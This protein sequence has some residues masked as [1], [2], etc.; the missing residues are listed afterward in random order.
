[1]HF[2]DYSGRL[3]FLGLVTAFFNYALGTYNSLLVLYATGV[4]HQSQAF[5]YQLYAAFNALVFTLPI[6]GGY[7]AG[8]FSYKLAAWVGTLF[9]FFA[10]LI[11]ACFSGEPAYAGFVLYLSL[12]LYAAGYGLALPAL[13]AMPGM[14]F[15]KDDPERAGG[16]TLF[17]ILM[18][19]GFLA[20]PI[21]GGYLSQKV[22]YQSAYIAAALALFFAVAL[23]TFGLKRVKFHE[24]YRPDHLRGAR[25][26]KVVGINSLM[27]VLVCPLA[28]LFLHE[29]RASNYVVAL[30][31]L[32][33][34]VIVLVLAQRQTAQMARKRLHA[35]LILMMI[36]LFFWVVYMLEPSVVTVLIKQHVNRR[37][38][39]YLIP[40]AAFYALDP[41]FVI[42]LGLGLSYVWR[43]LSQMG[44]MPSIPSKFSWAI[45]FMG[46]GCL[47]LVLA[48]HLSGLNT[49]ASGW[50][51]AAYLLFTTAELL[52]APISM[53]MIGRLAP[54]GSTGLLMGI[55]NL[56]VGFAAVLSGYFGRWVA[57][58]HGSSVVDSYAAY[59]HSFLLLGGAAVVVGVLSAV[60]APR[61]AQL[62]ER[63]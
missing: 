37:V 24:N 45:I 19:V 35:F 4:L 21:L 48:I 58:P 23:L 47:L 61:V 54:Q 55:F 43:Y 15:A 20:A 9:C 32:V 7:L 34:V 57:V 41:F 60:C 11:N 22:G 51:V 30:A 33:S 18:N 40:S 27:V 8:K 49:I 56:F 5:A 16:L 12:A 3:L 50:I 2:K 31:C 26:L 44:A 39:G 46:L 62:I 59:S 52:I 10:L 28:Y 13:F 29:T 63:V 42:V 1:M 25:R 17:Y 14:L 53:A 36:G 6:L 38:A